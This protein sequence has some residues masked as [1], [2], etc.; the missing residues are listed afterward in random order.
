M[1]GVD[2]GALISKLMTIE[3]T[4]KTHKTKNVS[5]GDIFSF[6]QFSKWT[7]YWIDSIFDNNSGYP[8][9]PAIGKLTVSALNDIRVRLVPV[10]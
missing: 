1:Y 5:F 4:P 10:F 7:H 8:C 9:N 3:S 6:R 2:R